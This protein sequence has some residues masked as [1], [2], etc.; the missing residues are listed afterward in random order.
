MPAAY[1]EFS[2]LHSTDPLPATD[3]PLSAA[4]DEPVPVSDVRHCSWSVGQ[5][6]FAL[7]GLVAVAA[8]GTA[9]VDSAPMLL[10]RP[11]AGSSGGPAY[12]VSAVD[13][14]ALTA[15]LKQLVRDCGCGPILVRLAWHDSG[16]YNASDG[17]GG[18]H[19]AQRF[20]GGESQ[21]PA[22]AGLSIARGLLQPYHE[23]YPAVGYADL[24]SLAAVVA[25]HELGG[26]AVPF[27]VGRGDAKSEAQCVAAGRLPDGSRGASHLRQVFYRMGFDDGQIVALSGAHTL[28]RC[29]AG[30][31]G[32]D[33]P[34][35]TDPLNFDNDYFLEL[36]GC[37]WEPTTVPQTGKPQME[38][39]A[40][41][42]LM[43]LYTD[44]ALVTDAALHVYT[45]RF[46]ESQ[47]EWF[48]AFGKAFQ[49]LQE[50]GHG[51]LV[52][53][54]LADQHAWATSSA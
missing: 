33:G 12:D 18:S 43:M 20:P 48:V 50:N 5:I 32:F 11:V 49:Q 54:E 52:D 25:I 51:G 21:D 29:H 45:K 16:T 14:I 7:V 46:A 37:G 53:I 10:S 27:R 22:N 9:A 13:W 38:C 2:R 15:D 1:V 24:W 6:S 4:T 8:L 41:P 47:A 44:W 31:S 34:W 36:L 40:R 35:T 39:P 30:R 26:P 23:R 17:T 3:D 28:G 19:G 42:G